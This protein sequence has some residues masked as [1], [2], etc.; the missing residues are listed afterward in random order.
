MLN[1][2]IDTVDVVL[3]VLKELENSDQL[4]GYWWMHQ[5]YMYW[6]FLQKRFMA[7]GYNTTNTDPRVIADY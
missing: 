5:K 1:N 2:Y 3:F 6:R 4:H 7:R